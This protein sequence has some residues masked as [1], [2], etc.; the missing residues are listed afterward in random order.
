MNEIKKSFNL[1]ILT[2]Q[3]FNKYTKIGTL[4]KIVLHFVFVQCVNLLCGLAPLLKVIRNV[5]GSHS[6]VVPYIFS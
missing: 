3:K 4:F 5:P 6:K 1:D 2:H